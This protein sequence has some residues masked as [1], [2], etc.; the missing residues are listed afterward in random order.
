MGPL[1]HE[2]RMV[3]GRYACTMCDHW[4]KSLS[5]KGLTCSKEVSSFLKF[6]LSLP[7][8]FTEGISLGPRRGPNSTT[9]HPRKDILWH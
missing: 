5:G 7:I 6:S 8:E 1:S 2:K 9:T 3:A 4:S